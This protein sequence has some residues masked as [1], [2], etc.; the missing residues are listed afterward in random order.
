MRKIRIKLQ[1]S[2]NKENTCVL[3]S[4]L[5]KIGF[6]SLNKSMKIINDTKNL[7][8]CFKYKNTIMN[9]NR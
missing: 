2:K 6:R 5:K 4:Q 9:S 1:K 3:K 8:K 7:K